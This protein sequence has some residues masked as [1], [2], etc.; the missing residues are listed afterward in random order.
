MSNK[1]PPIPPEQRSG[2]GPG[3][4]AEADAGA[5]ANRGRTDKPPTSRQARHGNIAQNTH[6]QGYQ[7]DR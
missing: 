4:P 5:D 3:E 7:Q 2:R 1:P 6:H